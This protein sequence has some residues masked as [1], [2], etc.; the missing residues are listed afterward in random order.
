MGMIGIDKEV[1]Y[2]F[3][4]GQTMPEEEVEIREWMDE[5][6]ENRREFFHE[7]KLF[8]LMILN[9]QTPDRPTLKISFFKK[10]FFIETLKMASVITI[11]FVLGFF[12]FKSTHT[13]N[14]KVA[15]QTVQVPYGQRVNLILS[16]GTVVWLNSGSRM[17]YPES[18]STG[19]REIN[20][21]GEAY[22]EVAHNK[23]KPFVVKTHLYDIEVLGTKFNVDAYSKEGSFEGALLEGKIKIT[24][25]GENRTLIL[26][27]SYKAVM[28]NNHLIV[29]EIEDYDVFRWK[30]GLICFKQETFI[31]ILKSFQK[32]YDLKIVIENSKLSNPVITGK[33]RLSDGVE[34]ALRVLQKDVKFKYKR[35]VDNNII[36]IQ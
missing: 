2:R 25:E 14:E 1:L 26:N 13:A 9:G 16:D 11:A 18:F 8:D 30:E 34:Y 4:N 10:R 5:S 12:Y 24:R 36:Y 20:L 3:F 27:P 22:F 28:E 7:R 17:T 15:M 29:K 6:D 31:E 33:F 23:E 21:D 19:K 32:Y 35:D